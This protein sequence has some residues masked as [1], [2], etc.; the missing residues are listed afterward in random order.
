MGKDQAQRR[1]GVKKIG[2]VMGALG[3][4]RPEVFSN[5]GS[6]VLD[7]PGVEKKSTYVLHIIVIIVFVVFVVFVNVVTTMWVGGQPALCSPR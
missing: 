3:G 4:L 2:Q 7:S 5:P 1:G 6:Q